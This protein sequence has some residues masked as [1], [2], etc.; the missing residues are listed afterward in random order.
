MNELVSVIIPS[1]ERYDLLLIAIESVL[2]QTYKPLEII[3]VNDNS[4]DQRYDQLHHNPNIKYIKSEN[5]LKFP[6]KVRNLGIKNS[7][8][9]WLSFLDDDDNWLPEKLEKQ[10]NFSGNYNFIC[11]DAFLDNSRYNKKVYLEYWNRNNPK[12]TNILDYE[13]LTRHN[14]II[15]S[16]V[17]VK[18]DLLYKVNLYDENRAHGEDY[19]TWLKIL[20]L[21]EKCLFLDESLMNYN[22]KTYKH[23]L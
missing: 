14:L 4:S 6:G 23:Y 12:N 19:T 1:Y 11:C 9:T 16:T 13:I 2:K 15:N 22:N 18:K 8:G 5:R 21:G 10:M 3:V 7:S 17:L 20:S